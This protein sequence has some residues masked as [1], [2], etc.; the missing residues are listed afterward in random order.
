[1]EKNSFGIIENKSLIIYSYSLDRKFEKKNISRIFVQEYRMLHYNI[2]SFFL[3]I[4]MIFFLKSEIITNILCFALVLFSLL[5]K[6]YIYK[7][8][9]IE[10]GSY[11]NFKI[12]KKQIR[13]AEV[14]IDLFLNKK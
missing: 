13:D 3:A 9:I 8:V 7:L 10:K 2:F 14:L 1:M 4:V 12:D 5:Y 11:V 6:K